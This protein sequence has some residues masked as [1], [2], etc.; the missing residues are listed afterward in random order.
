MKK[1]IKSI[2]ILIC[3]VFICMLWYMMIVSDKSDPNNDLVLDELNAYF[4]ETVYLKY[5]PNFDQIGEVQIYSTTKMN[6]YDEYINGNMVYST[7]AHI[8]AITDCL[9]NIKLVEASYDE[10]PNTSAD[11]S[12]R[13]YDNEKNIVGDFVLYGGVFIKDIYE[14]KLYRIKYTGSNIIDEL[15]DLVM[16]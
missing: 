5:T 2:C 6:H 1:L 8:K 16:D 13:Y 12:I 3:A 7:Q 15:N 11:S 14:D 4:K 10:L 9:N